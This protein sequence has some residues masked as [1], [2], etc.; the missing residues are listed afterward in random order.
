MSQDAG[1]TPQGE[2]E[3]SRTEQ[4]LDRLLA[5]AAELMARQGF[6]QTTIRDVAR[7]TGYSLAGM[8]YYFKSKE[9]LLFQIQLRTFTS[10]LEQQ[11]EALARGGTAEERL[12]RFV[13]GHL[14][15]FVEHFNELKVCTFELE[16]LSEEA[17]RE[18]EAVRRRYYRL[19]AGVIA[20]LMGRDGGNPE[21]DRAVR[22]ATLF[23][24]GSLN[25]IFMWFDPERDGPVDALAD[26][27]VDLV[28]HGVRAVARGR[29]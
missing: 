19:A 6:S 24:F 4:K 22:H 11:Q 10:L 12:R 17:Y 1:P 29:S 14:G 2:A 18:I 7:A 3:P 9:D 5:A 15:F 20:E 23:V 26:E 16:S 25:W 28:L 8:Y 27:V 21:T 13:R